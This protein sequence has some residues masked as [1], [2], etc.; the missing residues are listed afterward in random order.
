MELRCNT[1]KHM[2]RDFCSK[3]SKF[4]SNDY[5]KFQIGGAQGTYLGLFIYKSKC[6]VE[7]SIKPETEELTTFNVLY[8]I[9][10]LECMH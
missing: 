8:P 10:S 3:I 6:G 7:E 5:L 4:L 1:C 9:D 2:K